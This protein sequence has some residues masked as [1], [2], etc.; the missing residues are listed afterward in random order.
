MENLV[1]SRI[2][3]GL[4]E[5]VDFYFK[6]IYD[7]CIQTLHLLCEEAKATRSLLEVCDVDKYVFC[8]L[9]ENNVLVSKGLVGIL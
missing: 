3:D 8:C 1:Q 4:T 7:K 5:A 9:T 6:G 2:C